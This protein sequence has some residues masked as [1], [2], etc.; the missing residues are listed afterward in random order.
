MLWFEAW[1]SSSRCLLDLF[2]HLQVTWI[3]PVIRSFSIWLSCGERSGKNYRIITLILI[4]WYQITGFLTASSSCWV[5]AAES[6]RGS[7]CKLLFG[8]EISGGKFARAE[9]AWICVS[10]GSLSSS[11]I[12]LRASVP[13]IFL[14][15][16]ARFGRSDR[17]DALFSADSGFTGSRAIW[18]VRDRASIN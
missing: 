6:S 3:T 12:K 15:I 9:H 5:W 2:R 10:A 1:W 18:L 17:K 14:A 8:E 13:S 7:R 11:Q 4:M 16:S